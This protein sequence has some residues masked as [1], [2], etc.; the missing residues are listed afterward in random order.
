MHVH[1]WVPMHDQK[2]SDLIHVNKRK[3]AN[4]PASYFTF[5]YERTVYLLGGIKAVSLVLLSVQL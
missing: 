3:K 2:I 5:E 4:V 1:D